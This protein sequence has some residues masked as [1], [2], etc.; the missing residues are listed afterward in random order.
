MAKDKRSVLDDIADGIADGV[1]G[2]AEAIDRLL[3]PE[4]RKP[5]RALVPV[6][7]RPPQYPTRRDP[8]PYR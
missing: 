2:L 5:Q 6:P 7:I 4:S 1:R 8:Y 3:N